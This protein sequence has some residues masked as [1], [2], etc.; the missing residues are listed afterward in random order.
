ML[1]WYL[2]PC[3]LGLR[4]VVVVSKPLQIVGTLPWSWR[5]QRRLARV[6]GD[7]QGRSGASLTPRLH[8]RLRVCVYVCVSVRVR[9]HAVPVNHVVPAAS[10]G[11]SRVGA[12]PELA[13][14]DPPGSRGYTAIISDDSCV[15]GQPSV[16]KF[17]AAGGGPGGGASSG[18][19]CIA[20]SVLAVQ[21]PPGLRDGTA[22]PAWPWPY[23]GEARA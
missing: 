18:C 7:G 13:A 19:C 3:L 1:A 16:A 12:G 11:C 8:L 21:L 6:G 23:L 9:V 10:R 15:L 20:S 4:V 2:W 17:V 5:V 22:R 14:A